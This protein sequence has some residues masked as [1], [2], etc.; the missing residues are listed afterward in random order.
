MTRGERAQVW[1]RHAPDVPVVGVDR[2]ILATMGGVAWWT[3]SLFAA[4]R[5]VDGSGPPIG[6]AEV[7]VGC[8]MSDRGMR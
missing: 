2:G 7:V 8:R 1:I 6:V 4:G 5:G 3:S